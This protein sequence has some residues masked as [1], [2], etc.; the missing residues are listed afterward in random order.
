[1]IWVR[2]R[3]PAQMSE[4]L[5]LRK[6]RTIRGRLVTMTGKMKPCPLKV[7]HLHSEWF[8]D[9]VLLESGN[10][11]IMTLSYTQ[12]TNDTSLLTTYVGGSRRMFFYLLTLA[13]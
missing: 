9:M 2:Y 10:M 1:M 8:T 7:A 11:L 13:R 6:V 5:T 12:K 4:C 3:M